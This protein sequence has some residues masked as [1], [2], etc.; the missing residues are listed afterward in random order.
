MQSRTITIT[1]SELKRKNDLMYYVITNNLDK[2][3][4]S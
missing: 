3:I 4:P 2:I 1:N